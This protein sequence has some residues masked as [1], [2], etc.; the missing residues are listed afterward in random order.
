MRPGAGAAHLEARAE[1]VQ[2]LALFERD[3]ARDLFGIIGELL[4]DR[5]AELLALVLR[6]LR[7]AREGGLGRIDGVVEIGRGGFGRET[8]DIAGRRIAD[9][10]MVAGGDGLAADGQRVTL[11]GR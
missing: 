6:G 11:F 9:L 4:R 10:E 5:V 3:Q 7:P 8:D 1:A 2:R